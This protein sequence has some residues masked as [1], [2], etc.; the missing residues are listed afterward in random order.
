[1][2]I[3]I[4]GGS[5]LIGE[6]VTTA[7][8]RR[9]EVGV[10][11]RN[12]A[13][14]STGRPIR[15]DPAETRGSWQDEVAAADV[16]V[17]LAG[18]N[19]GEGR[20]SEAKK[21]RLVGSRIEA[22]RSLVDAMRRSERSER[23]LISASAVGIYGNRGDEI[24]EDD[25]PSGSGLLAD[26]GRAWEA[27][28]RQ[29]ESVSR[30]VIFR[31]GLV[32]SSRGG[33]LARMLPIFRAGVGGRLGDGTQW[34]PWIDL[35]DVAMLCDRVIDRRDAAGTYNAVAPEPVRNAE[36]TRE[37]ARAMHRPAILPAPAFALRLAFGQMADEMILASQRAVPRR[38]LAEGFELAQPEL[39]EALRWELARTR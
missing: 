30:V 11:T 29:A 33:A 14:V 6:A 25:A 13:K 19:A 4:S 23:L 27:E 3:V 16:V 35:D 38:L 34:W 28:A 15:W 2:K 7:L 1:M 21:R 18:E 39:G 5:G 24:L 31:F 12:P 9:G 8:A 36:F 37:L 22:T 17:N 20:W 32:L 10:L 26:L